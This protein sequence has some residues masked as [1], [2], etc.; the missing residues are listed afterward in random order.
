MTDE[1]IAELAPQIGVRDACVAGRRVAGQLLPAAPA[2]PAP[3]RPAPVPHRDRPQPRA[4]SAA[5]SRRSSTCCTATGSSTCPRPRC[6]RP[7]STRAST[8][9]RSRRSTGCCAKPGEVR[10][11]RRQATHPAKVKPELVANGPNQVWSWDITKLPARRNGPT[12][13]CT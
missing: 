4:L 6:G 5:S 9:A 7:C 1:A 3:E 10:E 2:S 12:T 8:W 13:T 11:R